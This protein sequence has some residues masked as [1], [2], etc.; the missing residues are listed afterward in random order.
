[1]TMLNFDA[2]KVAPSTGEQDPVPAGWY[3]I[4]MDQSEMKPTKDAASTGNA[5]LEC[6]FNILSGSYAGR[7]LFTRLNLRNHNPVATEIAYKEL[8]AICHAAGI[9]Q[10]QDSQ[11]LHG[12]P[13]KAKVKIR[14][15]DAQYG[16]QNEITTF[17]P[18][19]FV[20]DQPVAGA[21]A[22]GAVP[23]MQ[24]PAQPGP[25]QAGAVQ[26]PQQWAPPAAQA[27]QQQAPQQPW[28]QQPPPAQQPMQPPVQQPWQQQPQP[29]AQPPA[30]QPPAGAPPVQQ[31]MAQPPA[32]PP[33]QAQQ[34]P[35]A[36]ADGQPVVPPWQRQPGQ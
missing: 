6:R 26:P 30:W 31:P 25:W 29:A 14:P 3:D 27:P 15:G 24:Q 35:W 33:A 16:P 19:N 23:P 11:Q 12:L 21:V 5:F 18:A 22:P 1:M 9:L 36:G 4:A 7:K 2:S 34:Q 17:K 32:Q 28:Q 10:V 20:P 8:S 13:M